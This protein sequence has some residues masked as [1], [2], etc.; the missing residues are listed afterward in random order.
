MLPA[1][2]R[3]FMRTILAL[4]AAVLLSSV[5]LGQPDKTQP[6]PP[7][8]AP[9]P[10]PVTPPP[11]AT[12]AGQP[13]TP[14]PVVATPVPAKTPVPVPD[15]PIVKKQELEGGLIVEDMKIG[16]GYEVKP[17][18]AVV[19]YYHGTLK[20]GGK[21]FDSAF[22]KGE[23]IAFPLNGVIEG[24]Q[25]GVPGMKIGGIR[26]LTIPA[27]L[28][29]GEKAMGDSI[30][31]NSDL[32]FI[33]QL[34]DAV[35]SED[36]TVGTGTEATDS[37]VPAMVYTLKDK[38]GKEIEKCDA[39]NPYIWIPGEMRM[40]RVDPMQI[41]LAGMK[42][43]GK[44]KVTIPKEFNNANPSLTSTRPTGVPLEFDVE[45]IAVRNLPGQP[46]PQRH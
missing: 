44:R 10:K 9:A 36:V 42:V 11:P 2:E 34:V 18:G 3:I 7:P 6:T 21:V 32:V 16:E 43:G 24:W 30:P 27:K 4:S 19:A 45:L 39:K 23:P 15:M 40:G 38:D 25:K 20:D 1:Q 31:A 17:G 29:Y 14:P 46:Q 28:A 12:P 35:Q 33:I 8:P 13:N 26:K 5:A 22:E 41:A 37:C